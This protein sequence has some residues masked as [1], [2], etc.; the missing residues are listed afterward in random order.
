MTTCTWDKVA[1]PRRDCCLPS[2]GRTVTTTILLVCQQ[3]PQQTCREPEKGATTPFSVCEEGSL[4]PL[5][6]Y[7]VGSLA[8]CPFS[9]AEKWTGS[10]T[11]SEAGRARFSG[12]VAP[13]RDNVMSFSFHPPVP[14]DG[15]PLTH[16]PRREV[17]SG[18]V[19]RKVPTP[20]LLGVL[21]RQI[22]D[23]LFGLP[24]R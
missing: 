22:G 11:T 17:V 21:L 6:L 8:P 19:T 9:R 23:G 3:L 13:H 10:L 5:P 12:Q 16:S 1:R 24:A 15:F 2:G 4:G 18:S 20:R 7:A 14:G